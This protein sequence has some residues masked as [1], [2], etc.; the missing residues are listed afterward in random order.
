M[1]SCVPPIA[2]GHR[3]NRK[4]ATLEEHIPLTNQ[5]RTSDTLHTQNNILGRNTLVATNLRSYFSPPNPNHVNKHPNKNR[6]HGSHCQ[7]HA[8]AQDCHSHQGSH[9]AKSEATCRFRAQSA[10]FDT[11]TKLFQKRTCPSASQLI[12]V[13]P[14]ES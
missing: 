11:G 6:G 9:W 2:I 12:L 1:F 7:R 3:G 4:K 14:N 10:Q 5:L 13:I 8:S